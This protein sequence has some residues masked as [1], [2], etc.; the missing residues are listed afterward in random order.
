[1]PTVFWFSTLKPDVR[2]ED[3]E[4]W[5][6]TVDYVQAKK[7]PSILS[8]RIYRLHG[9]Y[10]DTATLSYDYL[11]IVEVTSIEAYRKDISQHPAAQV[12]IAEIGNY[13]DSMGDAW[14]NLIEA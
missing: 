12:I 5:A 10:T 14:G 11:E 6:R 1:V 4:H 3:Y 7:I 8:Y 2:P 13:I 9:T